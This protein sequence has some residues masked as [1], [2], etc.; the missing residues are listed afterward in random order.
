KILM[1]YGNSGA[2]DASNGDETFI[3]FDDFEGSGIDTTKWDGNTASFTVSDSILSTTTEKKNI[4]AKDVSIEDMR[5]KTKTKIDTGARG[6]IW[7][8][9]TETDTYYHYTTNTGY[10]GNYRYPNG[11][12]RLRKWYNDAETILDSSSYSHSTTWHIAE[13]LIDGN[14]ISFKYGDTTL[15]GTDTSISG[16]GTIMI[17]SDVLTSGG[18]YWDWIFLAKYTSPEPTWSSFGSEQ[19]QEGWVNTPPSL[20]NENPA[21]E[22]TNVNLQPTLSV[23]VTDADGNS[24]NVW[25]WTSEDGGT[26]WTLRNSTT[27]SDGNG[28]ITYNYNEANQYNTTYYWKVSANDSHDNTTKIYHFTT[29]PNQPPT[30]SNPYPANGSTDVELQPWCHVDVNDSEGDTMTLYWY[31]GKQGDISNIYKFPYTFSD[32]REDRYGAI[33]TKRHIILAVGGQDESYHYFDD[34]EIFN[35]SDPST[36]QVVANLTHTTSKAGVVYD[37]YNDCFY[38]Y[39]ARISGTTYSDKIHKI[40]ADDYDVTVLTEH[41]PSGIRSA[42]AVAFSTKQKCAYLLMGTTTSGDYKG[43]IWRHNPNNHTFLNTGASIDYDYTESG[44]AIYVPEQDCIYFFGG[45]PNY[46]ENKFIWRFNCTTETVTNLS[47]TNNVYA[48]YGAEGWGGYYNTDNGWIYIFAG[49]R[50]SSSPYYTNQIWKFSP[51]NYSTVNLTITM[52]KAQDDFF[53]VYSPYYHRGYLVSCICA[54]AGDNDQSKQKYIYSVNYSIS[55]TLQQTNSSVGNGTYYWHYTEANQKNKTYWWKVAANDGTNNVSKI[56]CFTTSEGR[57][58]QSIQSGWCTFSNTSSWQSLQQGWVSFSNQSTWTSI[59]AGWVS[60]ANQSNWQSIQSG[61]T[62]FSNQ[63]SWQSLQSGWVT[64]SNQPSWNSLES[65]WVS[66]SNQSSWNSLESGWCSFSN[67][68]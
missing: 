38:V 29:L 21:N 43:Q 5:I 58:W 33:D 35:L 4:W 48:P 52:E 20:S 51:F 62:T 57:T 17:A 13:L 2:S 66:F 31:S 45:R 34:V 30:I 3:F 1:Y 16:T 68:S 8:R 46:W 41:L 11:D 27:F 26:T 28:T 55:F 39:G 49:N 37:P 36:P 15:S 54:G 53:A 22:S 59:E 25:L 12:I 65:G 64:F 23:D 63:T 6:G 50:N 7:G 40:D 56:Y 61:W 32:G 24:T 19:S 47:A 67:Q 60:F 42:R 14:S 44:L 10:G 9:V 18:V